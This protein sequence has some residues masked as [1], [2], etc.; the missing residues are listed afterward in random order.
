MKII[1]KPRRCGKTYD[2]IFNHFL[3]KPMYLLVISEDEKLRII[4][5]YSLSNQEAK[6]IIP[7]QN[8]K[9]KIQ[10]IHASFS[11]DNADIFL[12]MAIGKPLDIISLNGQVLTNKRMNDTR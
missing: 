5:Q 10:G 2:L 1:N 11:M 7:W 6:R 4:R 3:K 12:Q 8:C 9:E